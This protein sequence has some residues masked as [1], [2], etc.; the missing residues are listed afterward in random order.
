[1]FRKPSFADVEQVVA[2]NVIDAMHAACDQ[3][4]AAGVP[5]A[6]IGGLAVGALGYPRT[7]RDVDFLVGDEA[8]IVHPGGVMTMAPGI[9]FAA[10][11]VRVDTLAA[12]PSEGH[13]LDAMRHAN[14]VDGVPVMP[15]GAIAYMK[16]EAGRAKDIADLVELVKAGADAGEAVAYLEAHAPEYVE[17]FADIVDQAATER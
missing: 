11:G 12:K 16:L 13:L 14:V 10:L 3:L 15:F 6:L 7:T 9:P 1:M 2:P 8:F 17:A 4:K 5:H